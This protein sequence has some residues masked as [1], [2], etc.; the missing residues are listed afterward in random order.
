LFIV[1]GSLIIELGIKLMANETNIH[2][3]SRLVKLSA[4]QEKD[5][6]P[7]PY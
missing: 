5:Y 6:N 1:I 4:L 2:R 7:Y 3:E